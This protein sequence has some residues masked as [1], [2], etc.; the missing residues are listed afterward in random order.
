[1][2]ARE[3]LARSPPLRALPMARSTDMGVGITTAGALLSDTL[4]RALSLTAALPL[5]L[6]LPV[7]ATST[8]PLTDDAA[9][10][11]RAAPTPG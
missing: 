4:D 6:P 8:L 2:A 3:V 7:T 10:G 1:M 5:P 11:D 9:R